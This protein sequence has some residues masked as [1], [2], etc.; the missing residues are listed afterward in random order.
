MGSQTRG[1][2]AGSSCR[3]PPPVCSPIWF[4]PRSTRTRCLMTGKLPRDVATKKTRSFRF[5]TMVAWISAA[6]PTST[7]DDLARP[8]PAEIVSRRH[9]TRVKE[10]VVIGDTPADVRCCTAIGRENRRRR[11]RESPFGRPSLRKKPSPKFLPTTSQHRS[12][13]RPIDDGIERNFFRSEGAGLG[14]ENF[15]FTPRILKVGFGF[16]SQSDGNCSCP[17][18]N[19]RRRFPMRLGEPHPGV[20]HPC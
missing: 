4:S 16:Q 6:I 18:T 17:F 8:P 7:G 10:I 13:A 3:N 20:S 14:V 11:P 12:R 19:S 5:A 2:R 1:V 9:G 15:V